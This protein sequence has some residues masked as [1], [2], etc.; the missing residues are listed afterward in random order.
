[1]PLTGTTIYETYKINNDIKRQE[2][3]F[4]Q[5]SLSCGKVIVGRRARIVMEVGNMTRR[6]CGLPDENIQRDWFLSDLFFEAFADVD[7]DR[8]PLAVSER[9]LRTIRQEPSS[10]LFHYLTQASASER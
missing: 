8:Q 5:S 9:L 1:L 3:A 10:Y 7:D 2:L 4:V 6:I